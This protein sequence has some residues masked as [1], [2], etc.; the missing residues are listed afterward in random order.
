M[1]VVAWMTKNFRL[2]LWKQNTCQH[3]FPF[4]K[5]LM[6]RFHDEKKMKNFL[7]SRFVSSCI[8]CL[9]ACFVRFCSIA[10]LSNIQGLNLELKLRR[11]ISIYRTCNIIIKVSSIFN[12]V[13][14]YHYMKLIPFLHFSIFCSRSSVISGNLEWRKI[15]NY[16]KMRDC[17]KNI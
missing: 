2:W 10:L 11:T 6:E 8:P 7:Y 4:H 16:V 17:F 13:F 1:L 9:F 5:K 14:P 3:N 15:S 12:T